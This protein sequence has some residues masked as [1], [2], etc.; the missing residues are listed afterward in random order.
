MGIARKGGGVSTLARMVWGTYLEKM[1]K[2]MVKMVKSRLKKNA[3]ECPFECGWG[4]AKAKRAMPK[5][6]PRE[7]EGG[8]PNSPSALSAGAGKHIVN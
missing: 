5:C 8:F 6:P 2:K 7:F 3:P 1:V 4:G